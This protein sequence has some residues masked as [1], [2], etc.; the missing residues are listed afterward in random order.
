MSG[1]A[2]DV[3]GDVGGGRVAVLPL[4]A[5]AGP[6]AGLGLADDVQN[7]GRVGLDGGAEDEL[8]GFHAAKVAI[9]RP[10]RDEV[11]LR[12]SLCHDGLSVFVTICV[13][14]LPFVPWHVF[15]PFHERSRSER[16]G[17]KSKC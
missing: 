11:S 12:M 2:D 16:G 8:V 6:H 4:A 9:L 10:N 1:S 14:T 5:A 13:T 3:A 7:A 15:C 17:W